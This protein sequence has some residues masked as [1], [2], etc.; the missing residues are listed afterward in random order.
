M[1]LLTD[2][3]L[4]VMEYIG[5]L[6]LARPSALEGAT[7][8]RK[9]MRT[10]HYGHASCDTVLKS[11]QRSINAASACPGSHIYSEIVHIVAGRELPFKF[12]S[13]A[14]ANP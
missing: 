10:S 8:L 12:H 1:E 4:L 6:W 2:W 5:R 3:L 13:K 11:T 7:S 14:D 9:R